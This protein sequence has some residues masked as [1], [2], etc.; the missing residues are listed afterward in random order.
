LVIIAF[1]PIHGTE[2]AKVKPP[3]PTDIA[4]VTAT[5]RLML[6]KTPLVLGCVRPKGKH[7]AETDV[8]ALKA[9]ADAIAFPSEEAVNYA[10][11]QGYALSF[12]SYCCAQIY[13][14]AALIIL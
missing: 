6:P 9:G 1:M 3:T 10:E 7:R 11:T 8:L 12:S 2:M 5:A 13:A 4:K 14:D